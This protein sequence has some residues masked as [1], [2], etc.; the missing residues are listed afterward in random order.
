[1]SMPNAASGST[2]VEVEKKSGKKE[3]KR[4]VAVVG[5]DYP[6]EKDNTPIR[7]EPGEE[8]LNLRRAALEEELRAG[9]IK[10]GVVEEV[11]VPTE[12]S[13]EEEQA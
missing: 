11:V 13:G 6:S 9:N 12:E 5:L 10:E 4:Y 8:V 7:V 1:M 3:P 2:R